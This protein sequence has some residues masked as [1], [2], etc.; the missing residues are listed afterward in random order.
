MKIEK[1]F[2]FI[3]AS[4]FISFVCFMG[5]SAAAETVLGV[6]WLYQHKDTSMLCLEG[7]NETG[8]HPWDAPHPRHDVHGNTYCYSAAT[9][10]VANYLLN[11][12]HPGKTLS[13]DR[14]SFTYGEHYAGEGYPP[15]FAFKHGGTSGHAL[16]WA[17]SPNGDNCSGSSFS[18]LMNYID[19]GRPMAVAWSGHYR[20]IDGYR[21]NSSGQ[22]VHILDPWPVTEP[23]DND[24]WML[25]S[26]I[27]SSYY[28][29][30]APDSPTSVKFDEPEIWMDSDSDGIVDFDEINRFGTSSTDA[31]SD[32]DG[33]ADKEDI[34]EYVFDAAGTYGPPTFYQQMRLDLET[35]YPAK[36]DTS[37][38]PDGVGDVIVVTMHLNAGHP[39]FPHINYDVNTGLPV[40]WTDNWPLIDNIIA[41]A[42]FDGDGLRKELDPDNDND[43]LLDGQED[44]NS[45]GIFEID[46]DETSNFNPDTVLPTT[47]FSVSGPTYINNLGMLCVDS[48]TRHLITAEDDGPDDYSGVYA[49]YYR[50]YFQS[51]TPGSFVSYG[52]PFML[53]GSDG[54]R[55]I[56][57]YSKD[58]AG[59]KE[60]I[61]DVIECLDNNPPVLTCPADTFVEC[62][63]DAPP[64][65][66]GWATAI[67]ACDTE[68]TLVY[69]DVVSAGAC[70]NT[71]VISRTWTSADTFGHNS[72]CVQII[73][74]VDTTPPVISSD[75]PGAITPPDAPISFTAS[76]TDNCDDAPVV[77]ITG[78]DCF[79]YTNKGKRIDKTESCMVSFWGNSI[80][81]Q[82]S[83]G[84]GTHITWNVQATDGCGN[85]SEESFEIAV[86]RP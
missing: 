74:K 49:S 70:P 77:Q 72:I 86:E 65:V 4:S 16:D 13:Q 42:D 43:G 10:M 40:S 12:L 75:V 54:I 37:D 55:Q 18:D 73:E 66:T 31:D 5:I 38:P 50:H 36:A 9:A 8:D 34:R 68:P 17:V 61:N 22:F 41:R 27:P 78:Y 82:D 11:T 84:V 14:I 79:K 53:T 44:T 62:D 56:D 32:F 15:D 33:V 52:G 21:D 71:E 35:S 46:L 47:S 83:G 80:T 45:N 29:Y 28:C 67:D 60:T 57:Y 64:E 6:P 39:I 63:E 30:A 7:D 85:L 26:N 23:S 25:F 81:I 59:N 58:V 1:K 20:V 76:A 51:D 48:T 24:K 2:L 3:I 19:N 69:S